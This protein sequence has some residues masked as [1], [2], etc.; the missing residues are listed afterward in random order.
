MAPLFLVQDQT[1]SCWQAK[2]HVFPQGSFYLQ[3]IFFINGRNTSFIDCKHK[4]MLLK[5]ELHLTNLVSCTVF[6]IR[7]K[8]YHNLVPGMNSMFLFKSND[9]SQLELYFNVK[10]DRGLCHVAKNCQPVQSYIFFKGTHTVYKKT[11][12]RPGSKV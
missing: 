7:I 11:E 6:Y 8:A 2:K 1:K 4:H 5:T 9:T 12:I 3:G 10:M